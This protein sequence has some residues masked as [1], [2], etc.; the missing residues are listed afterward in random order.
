MAGDSYEVKFK[1]LQKQRDAEIDSFQEE[2]KAMQKIIDEQKSKIV[3]LNERLNY[4]EKG[5]T[6]IIDDIEVHKKILTF[7]AR[8]YNVVE[9]RDKLSQLGIDYNVDDINIIVNSI[10]L[11]DNDLILHYENEKTAF[12]EQIKIDKNIQKE[13]LLRDNQFLIDKARIMIDK[14]EKSDDGE[15]LGKYMDKYDKYINTRTKLLGDVVLESEDITDNS[16][17]IL[18]DTMEEYNDN[19]SNIIK[20]NINPSN[21]KTIKNL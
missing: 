6:I 17:N 5:K 16:L 18:K 9:I 2:K 10:D 12:E 21:I 15:T 3:D 14:A 13:A 1:R 4:Y 7:R 20:L 19:V 11:L 8:Q